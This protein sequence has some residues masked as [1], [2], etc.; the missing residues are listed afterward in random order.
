MSQG[1]WGEEKKRAAPCGRPESLISGFI[2]VHLQENNENHENQKTRG[3]TDEIQ[4]KEES[5]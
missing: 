3:A 5:H 1:D 2:S 4:K